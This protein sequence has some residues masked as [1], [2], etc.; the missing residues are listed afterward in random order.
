MKVELVFASASG[1]INKTIYPQLSSRS[2][3]PIFFIHIQ[4]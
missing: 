3:F 1:G 2:Y 4:Y